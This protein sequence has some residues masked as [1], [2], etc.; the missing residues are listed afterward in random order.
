MSTARIR[1]IK[2]P[3]IAATATALNGAPTGDVGIEAA[4]GIGGWQYVRATA[5]VL[6]N[7]TDFAEYRFWTRDEASSI[8]APDNRI[9]GNGKFR[10]T[11]G[12]DG[13]AVTETLHIIGADRVYL[14]QTGRTDADVRSVAYLTLVNDPQV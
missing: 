6:V 13:D 2:E 9:N 11:E 14:E 7:A 12:V 3:F 5:K 10:A 4:R 1:P 8:W